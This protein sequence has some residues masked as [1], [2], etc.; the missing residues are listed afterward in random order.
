MALRGW[1]RTAIIG[2][3]RG[4]LQKRNEAHTPLAVAESFATIKWGRGRAVNENIVEKS[5]RLYTRLEDTPSA[6]EWIMKA[7]ALWGRGSPWEEWTKLA[8]T[9]QLPTAARTALG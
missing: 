3:R 7:Q 5:L 9:I 6:V 2:Q 8:A 1:N 4:D